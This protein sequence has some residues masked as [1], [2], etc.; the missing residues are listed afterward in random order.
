[1]T[2]IQPASPPTPPVFTPNADGTPWTDGQWNQ[3]GVDCA[4]YLATLLSYGQT[5]VQAQLDALTPALTAANSDL[6][7]KST[8]LSAG[9]IAADGGATLKTSAPAMGGIANG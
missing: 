5:R 6:A 8:A 9:A 1:M 4:Q 2:D 3:W 7:T